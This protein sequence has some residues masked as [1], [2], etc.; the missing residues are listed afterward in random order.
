MVDETGSSSPLLAHLST[1]QK[2]VFHLLDGGSSDHSAEERMREDEAHHR[3]R[4]A[5]AARR[6]ANNS[7]SHSDV[8]DL[9]EVEAEA[10]LTGVSPLPV[11]KGKAKAE[12]GSDDEDG[13][14]AP[15]A[16][17]VE[18]MWEHCGKHF[19]ALN[20][21]IDHLHTDHIGTHK[22]RYT[23]EWVGCP[24]KGKNQTS[25]FALLSHLRSHTGEKPFTCPLPECDKSFTRSDALAKHMRLQ[26]Q[27]LPTGTRRGKPRRAAR[28][29]IVK[30][31]DDDGEEGEDND[32]VSLSDYEP[33]D[34]PPVRHHQTFTDE[35]LGIERDP[36]DDEQDEK[37]L[38]SM[39]EKG[40]EVLKQYWDV[41]T[42]TIVPEEDDPETDEEDLAAAAAAAA[43]EHSHNTRR[44]SKRFKPSPM[45][46]I[47]NSMPGPGSGTA[48]AASPKEKLEP[49]PDQRYKKLYLIE[50]AKM[51]FLQA[52]NAEI[53]KEIK[54]LLQEEAKASAQKTD[55]LEEVLTLELGQ[56]VDAIFSPRGTPVPMPTYTE[57][58]GPP[59]PL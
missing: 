30:A 48:G 2:R 8:T 46:L 16:A 3:D 55:V 10:E 38:L 5:K 29:S 44:N 58:R 47:T 50:K 17:T 15:G 1:G 34:K 22:A 52:E 53:R 56:D 7:D 25:R 35:Q 54:E 27:M 31:G 49:T 32:M 14:A 23:C 28:S 41:G 19:T 36:F 26:H 13:E 9:D 12:G 43:T 59:P 57:L 11:A 20:A 39:R 45:D 6:D 40:A 42:G 51:K 4:K 18:C 21:L 37:V 33:I 24:R